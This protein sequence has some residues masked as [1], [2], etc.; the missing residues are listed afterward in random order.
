NSLFYKTQTGAN[1]ADVLTSVIATAA[2]AGINVFDY[3]NAIQRNK[4]A[5]K[6]NP[7]QWLPWD[8]KAEK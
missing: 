3:L 8:F 5:V 2:S 7:D 6:A 1:V 4:A